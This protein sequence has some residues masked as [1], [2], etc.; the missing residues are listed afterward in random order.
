MTE[1]DQQEPRLRGFARMSADDR[2][3]I[4]SMGGKACTAESRAFSRDRTLATEA[5]RKG[6]RV[7]KRKPTSR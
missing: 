1:P 7:S 3:R 6:G 4:A 5:G 2:K